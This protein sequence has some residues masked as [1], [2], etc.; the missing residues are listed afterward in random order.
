MKIVGFQSGHDVSYC[1]LE[2]GIPVR[3]EEL[4]RFSREKEPPGC[5]LKFFFERN[6]DIKEG[7]I[8][9]FAFGNYLPP[10]VDRFSVIDEESYHRAT[11]IC[12]GNMKQF[13]HHQSHASNAYYTSN[14][15]EALIF[16]A[17]GGGSGLMQVPIHN[18]DEEEVGQCT[19]AVSITLGV[20]KGT[21]D[22]ISDDIAQELYPDGPFSPEGEAYKKLLKDN[23]PPG[24]K[25]VFPKNRPI[26]LGRLWNNVTKK[27]YGLSIGYPL[28]NQ[29]GTVMAMATLGKP[30]YMYMFTS[31]DMLFGIA[32]TGHMENQRLKTTTR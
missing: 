25:V 2:D 10:S 21:G 16:T 24:C 6:P 11:H 17:D 23:Y 8:D 28:G 4:E 27:V 15:K 14:F 19:A 32:P 13:Q 12:K 29:A 7:D 5:G 9:G 31:I 30:L 3:H 26:N 20:Y 22:I 1:I 18:E